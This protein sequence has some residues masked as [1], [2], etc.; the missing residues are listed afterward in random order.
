MNNAYLWDKTGDDAEIERLE[1][2]LRVFRYEVTLAPAVEK[3]ESVNAPRYRLAWSL[4]FAFTALAVAAGVGLWLML[5]DVEQAGEVAHSKT[6]SVES[7]MGIEAETPVT[8]LSRPLAIDLASTPR[9]VRKIYSRP[10]RYS[11]V[12]ATN[13]PARVR[14]KAVEL[15]PE[16]RAAYDQVVLALA[17]TSSKLKMVQDKV[18]GDHAGAPSA[19]DNK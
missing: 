15:T 2:Q 11:Q 13:R 6:V 18:N 12:A 9:P 7:P 8:E 14:E 17:I 16:E 5:P 19:K 3:P 1:A 4:G 10:Q